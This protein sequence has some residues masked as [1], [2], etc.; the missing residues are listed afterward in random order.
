L[1]SPTFSQLL[2]SGEWKKEGL[3]SPTV[4]FMIHISRKLCAGMDVVFKRHP[5]TY[6]HISLRGA[7]GFVEADLRVNN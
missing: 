1:K 6:L 3:Y 2:Y 5:S 7:C 4:V